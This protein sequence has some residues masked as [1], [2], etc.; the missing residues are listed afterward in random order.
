MRKQRPEPT[1]TIA[2]PEAIEKAQWRLAQLLAD[3]Y[4]EHEEEI[5]ERIRKRLGKTIIDSYINKRLKVDK[6]Q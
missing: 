1:C 4:F 5:N 3:I 2:N 6:A